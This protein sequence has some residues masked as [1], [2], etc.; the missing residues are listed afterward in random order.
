LKSPLR[1]FQISNLTP[2]SRRHVMR[3]GWIAALVLTTALPGWASSFNVREYGA[4]GKK[5]DGVRPAI[6]KAIDACAATGGGMVYFPPGDYTS[7][8]IHS[9]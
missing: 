6:Q 8:T 1:A 2:V 7:G 4:T 9:T 3:A 5:F